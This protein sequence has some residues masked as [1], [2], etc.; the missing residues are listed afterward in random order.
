M[1]WL[2]KDEREE[3][4]FW[5]THDS[6]KL[7]EETGPVDVVFV[8]A[9]PPKKQMSLRLDPDAI[10]QL[11]AIAARKGIGYQTLIRIWVMEQL[12]QEG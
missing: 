5:D 10:E 9:R 1:G 8:N 7:L 3:A 12:A 2:P 4:E 6:T 11:K